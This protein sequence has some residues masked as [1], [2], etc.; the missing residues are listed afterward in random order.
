MELIKAAGLCGCF[1]EIGGRGGAGDGTDQGRRPL[2]CFDEIGG[3]GAGRS[4]NTPV[5][6]FAGASMPVSG[7][8]K[9]HDTA[10]IGQ[11]PSAHAARVMKAERAFESGSD[12]IHGEGHTHF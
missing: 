5:P 11:S 10:G 9:P 12:S 1:D 2:R 6:A 4:P 3:R 8:K 7:R